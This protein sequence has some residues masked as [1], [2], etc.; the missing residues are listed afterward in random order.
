MNILCSKTRNLKQ[1]VHYGIKIRNYKTDWNL[2]KIRKSFKILTRRA[3]LAVPT[4]HIK[5]T[6]PRVPKS[7]AAN[8]ECS[9]I[10]ERIGVFLET[11]LIVNLPD[12]CPMNYTVIQE[13]WQHHRWFR[14]EKVY[15]GQKISLTVN[16]WI[17]WWRQHWKGVTIS[18]HTSE[19]QSVSKENCLFDQWIFST[20]WILWWNSRIIGIVQYYIG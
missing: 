15:D 9:E 19:R 13:I 1:W 4:I 8:P 17:W 11:F 14:E 2:L 3:V 12:E 18:K 5:L 16:S 7:Q 20:Y 6:F 10:H